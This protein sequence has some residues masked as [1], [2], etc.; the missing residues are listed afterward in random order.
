[1]IDASFIYITLLVLYTITIFSIISVVISENRNPFKSIA[2][3]TVLFLLPIIG[4]IVYLVFGRSLKS[5]RMISK[6]QR[7]ILLARNNFNGVEDIES[8]GLSAE[9]LQQIRLAK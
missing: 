9:S 7:R 1:M 2:W 5:R 3:I 8:L 4:M 6:G